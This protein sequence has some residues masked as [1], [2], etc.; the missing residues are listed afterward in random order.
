MSAPSA[1]PTSPL[2]G[3]TVRA[4]MQLGLFHCPPDAD[5]RTLAR[6][7]VQRSIHCVVV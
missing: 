3:K 1:T 7:M 2:R 5:L 4:A 6:T